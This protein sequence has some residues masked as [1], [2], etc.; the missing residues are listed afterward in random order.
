MLPRLA[1]SRPRGPCPCVRGSTGRKAGPARPGP[2]RDARPVRDIRS[3]RGP[4]DRTCVRLA[5]PHP[6]PSSA[7]VAWIPTY[8]TKIQENLSE[9]E[10]AAGM[11]L[12]G[13]LGSFPRDPPSCSKPILA[14][15]ASIYAAGVGEVVGYLKKQF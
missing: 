9:G 11:T 5:G 6:S 13:S 3:R 7:R 10:K 15:A 2:A 12:R 1:R 8:K 4:T 14:S